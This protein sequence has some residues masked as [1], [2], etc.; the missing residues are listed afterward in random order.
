MKALIG[1]LGKCAFLHGFEK[2]ENVFLSQKSTS[3]IFT[4]N[5]NTE[6]QADH[7]TLQYSF[8]KY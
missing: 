4:K 2:I 1:W 6:S 5:Y 8:Y 7:L 3:V